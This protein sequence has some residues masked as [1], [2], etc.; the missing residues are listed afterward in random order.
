MAEK[1]VDGD[2]STFGN[3]STESY[4]SSEKGIQ[5]VG[6]HTH[7]ITTKGTN[8]SIGGGS[9]PLKKPSTTLIK[10]KVM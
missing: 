9:A 5:S 3:T 1:L 7:S 8:S 4:I 2:A 10:K 6:N